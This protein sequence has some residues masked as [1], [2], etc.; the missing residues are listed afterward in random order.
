MCLLPPLR[1]A[2]GWTC[3]PDTLIRTF[4]AVLDPTRG[5]QAY[6]GP[7]SR[8]C[9]PGS[10]HAYA[11]VQKRVY[12]DR[13]RKLQVARIVAHQT[14]GSRRRGARRVVCH[15]QPRCHPEATALPY[16]TP[17]LDRF[18]YGMNMPAWLPLLGMRASRQAASF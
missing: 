2:D 13:Y 9:V 12:F 18:A 11:A 6:S 4:N 10:G 7:G 16:S 3:L 17:L 15:A 5:P 8:A 14:W 1:H